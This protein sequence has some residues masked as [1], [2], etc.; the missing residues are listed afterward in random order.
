V[1]KRSE[2]LSSIACESDQKTEKVGIHR[3]YV[4][5]WALKDSVKITIVSMGKT[6]NGIPLP[7]GDKHVVNKW[8]LDLKIA[9]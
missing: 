4:C 2:D 7:S 3:F 6:L 8:Q 9:V 1:L 5:R